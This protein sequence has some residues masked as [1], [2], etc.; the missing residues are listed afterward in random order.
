MFWQNT[1]MYVMLPQRDNFFQGKSYGEKFCLHTSRSASD[2]ESRVLSNKTLLDL[3]VLQ[4]ELE[5]S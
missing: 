2:E 1:E 3:S 5:K 4:Y